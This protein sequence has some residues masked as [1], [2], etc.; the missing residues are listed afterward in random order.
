MNKNS[1]FHKIL[2]NHIVLFLCVIFVLMTI[3]AA[4]VCIYIK[5]NERVL[6]AQQMSSYV[7]QLQNQL[8][9]A[10]EKSELVAMN[11]DISS[12]LN[13]HDIGISRSYSNSELI[14]NFINTVSTPNANSSITIYT[15]NHDFYTS[16]HVKPSSELKNFDRL[17]KQLK[18]SASAIIWQKNIASAKSASKTIT[19]YRRFLNDDRHI[20]KTDI[21]VLPSEE[22]AA[23]T[24]INHGEEANRKNYIYAPINSEFELAAKIDTQ[25]LAKYYTLIITLFVLF[26]LFLCAALYA[27]LQ[28]TTKS[29]TI[30]FKKLLTTLDTD[31]VTNINSILVDSDSDYNEMKI[32][33][34]CIRHLIDIIQLEEMKSKKAII[35][36]NALEFE[37]LQSKFNPHLLY[38]SLSAVVLLAYKKHNYEIVTVVDNLVDYYRLILKLPSEI[39]L[40]AEASL[41]QKFVGICE[42]SQD[43][44]I[45]LS[46]DFPG[47][48]L[49]KNIP[50][51]ALQPFVENSVLHGFTAELDTPAIS[52]CG[53]IK[54]GLIYIE[55][56]DNG[57]GM[58]DDILC[59]LN[60]TD[61]LNNYAL[62]KNS[63]HKSY[64][65]SNTYKRLN[66][67][68]DGK[69]SMKYEQ[70][71]PGIK[72]TL[73]FPL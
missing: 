37:L 28:L 7:S 36:K 47:E 8:T 57:V 49:D 42:I 65:L 51:M 31:T 15:T 43:I 41:I 58:P 27:V 53:Y 62:N 67:Y 9:S 66:I 18:S 21:Y 1:I 26:Y 38:N 11:T 46:I 6:T 3:A 5:N 64:G 48:I 52:L 72:V 23:F 71:N 70:L 32:I 16:N 73:S 55:I 45:N 59:N 25:K 24:L 68:F 29:I 2:Y 39:T 20:I 22:Y 33:K 14:S 30:N 50:N 13:E 56:S 34:H 69:F 40:G 12:A 4:G 61:A 60:N 63:L 19:F 35:D 17:M 54:D 44:K 10:V